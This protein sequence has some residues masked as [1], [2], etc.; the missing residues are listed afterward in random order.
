MNILHS[1]YQPLQE[2]GKLGGVIFWTETSDAPQ[3]EPQ[4]G[5]TAKPP[6]PKEHPF[7]APPNLDGEKRTLALRLPAVKG[8]PLPSP[9]LIHNW[10]IVTDEP[11]Y[12]QR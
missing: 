5:R 10:D 2:H 8:I 7:A 11:I 1:H 3:P 9:G 6:K 4:R 12:T